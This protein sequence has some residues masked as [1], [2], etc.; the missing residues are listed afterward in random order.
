MPATPQTRIVMEEW[1]RACRDAHHAEPPQSLA[2][3]NE[4]PIATF[5]GRV[6]DEQAIADAGQWPRA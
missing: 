2:R 1:R 4:D 3:E 5:C 6:A